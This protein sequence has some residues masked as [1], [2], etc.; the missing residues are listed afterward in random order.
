MENHQH[1][2]TTCSDHELTVGFNL[3]KEHKEHSKMLVDGHFKEELI[4]RRQ[5]GKSY[6]EVH[7]G[8]INGE[9]NDNSANIKTNLEN[10]EQITEFKRQWEAEFKPSI[11]QP[12]KALIA[13]FKKFVFEMSGE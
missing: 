2:V 11:G 9:L 5:I 6:Y 4:H 12:N 13:I 7:L 1:D 10:E 3:F 8:L